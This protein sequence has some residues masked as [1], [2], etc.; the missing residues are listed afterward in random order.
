M[1]NNFNLYKVDFN[2]FSGLNYGYFN[3]YCCTGA[4]KAREIASS[5][6]ELIK[7][8]PSIIDRKLLMESKQAVFTNILFSLE[9]LSLMAEYVSMQNLSNQ[10]ILTPAQ[11]VKTIEQ[12][13]NQQIE[14]ILNEISKKAH[15]IV[16]ISNQNR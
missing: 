12:I 11:L 15:Q 5:Y 3:F 14:N 2:L 1:K 7:A 13:P 8:I 16:V 4:D 10:D 6:Q 9:K